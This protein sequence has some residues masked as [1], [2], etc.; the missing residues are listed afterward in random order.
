[1][2]LLIYLFSVCGKRVDAKNIY[3]QSFLEQK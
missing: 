3:G 1:M 2:Y